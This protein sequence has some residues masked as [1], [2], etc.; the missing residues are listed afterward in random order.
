MLEDMFVMY[1]DQLNV[2][3]SSFI[4]YMCHFFAVRLFSQDPPLFQHFWITKYNTINWV[5]LLLMEFQILFWLSVYDVV[6]IS[7]SLQVD[8]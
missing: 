3:T 8:F 1:N 5:I 7:H 2:L 4:L 6:P